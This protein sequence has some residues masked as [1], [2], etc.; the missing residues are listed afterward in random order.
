MKRLIIITAYDM[1]PEYKA[2]GLSINISEDDNS[3]DL[4]LAKEVAEYFQIDTK[5]A[6]QTILHITSVVKEWRSLANYFGISKSEQ[7]IM[8]GAFKQADI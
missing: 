7:E 2:S 3:L 8:S 4:D 6:D 5:R 1:N